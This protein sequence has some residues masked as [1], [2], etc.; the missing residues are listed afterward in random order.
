MIEV[1][2]TRNKINRTE[3]VYDFAPRDGASNRE[4]SRQI[5]IANRR[6]GKL[7][8]VGNLDIEVPEDVHPTVFMGKTRTQAFRSIR[9]AN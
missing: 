1:S 5:R 4:I 2:R 9:K 8:R 3:H 7:L 6:A